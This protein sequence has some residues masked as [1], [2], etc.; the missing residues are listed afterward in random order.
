MNQWQ[1]WNNQVIN[2]Q[3]GF[4]QNDYDQTGKDLMHITHLVNDLLGMF[5]YQALLFSF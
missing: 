4:F 1:E 2:I 5:M 3:R